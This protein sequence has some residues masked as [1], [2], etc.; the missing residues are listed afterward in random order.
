VSDYIELSYW[1]VGLAGGLILVNGLLSLWL[2]LNLG[3][4]LALASVRTVV[5]LTLIGFILRFVFAVERWYWVLLLLMVMT[6]IAGYLSTE[7]CKLRYRGM[8]RDSMVSLW[9]GSWTVAAIAIFVIVSVEPWYR[10]QYT[11][12]ILGMI[13][14]NSLTGVSLGLD[15]FTQSLA[16]RRHEVEGL[17]ALGASGWEAARPHAAEALRAAMTPTLNAMAAVGIV[18]LPG[19]MTGQ[20]LAGVD[21]LAAVKYQIMIMFLL[22]SSTA[23][24]SVVAVLLAFRRLFNDQHQF[25]FFLLRGGRNT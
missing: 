3:R 24:G 19:M 17:L 22:A 21:P 4:G 11:I 23:I 25:M 14:G 10:P 5:Q 20:L 16:Q 13:L 9:S 15:R 2:R 12:P 6:S 18:S 8:R 1:E 7:R